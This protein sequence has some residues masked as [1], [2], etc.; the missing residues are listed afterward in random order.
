MSKLGFGGFIELMRSGGV[1]WDL[2]SSLY[3]HIY[4]FSLLQQFPFPNYRTDFAMDVISLMMPL[5]VMLGFM[6]SVM[7]IIK[8]CNELGFTI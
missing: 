4:F 3:I 5:L 6:Y 1:W 8:V 7:T 2:R